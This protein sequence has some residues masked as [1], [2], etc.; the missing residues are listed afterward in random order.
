MHYPQILERPGD[1]ARVSAPT[2]AR[3]IR[4]RNRALVLRTLM[5]HAAASRA[6]LSR[7]TGLARPTISE[8]VRD[9]LDDGVIRE[10]GMSQDARPG[11]PAVMLEFDQRAVQVIALD[12]STP[13]RI[14]GALATP[15]G[16]IDHRADVALD[17]A[18][19]AT[20]IA[21]LAVDLAGRA[22]SAPLGIG[23][24]APSG[25][26]ALLGLGPRLADDLALPV[27]VFDDADLV[28]DAELRF[29]AVGTD[30]LL[31]RLGGRIGTAIRVVG[32]DGAPVE[33]SI[34]ARELAHVVAG[35]DP[36]DRC[37]CGR[38][39][40]VHAWAST[41]ALRRRLDEP[42]A[43]RDAVLAEAGA[44]LG[45]SLS[46]IAAAVD[47]PSI[48]LSGPSDIATPAFVEA[49]ATAVRAASHP[50]LGPA[51][52]SSTLDDAVLRGAAARVVAAAFSPR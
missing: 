39:G 33:R 25:S 19:P 37:L 5:E 35:G 42:G 15:D 49:T 3:A 40:C 2:H 23:I 11:K 7:L 1:R 4:E 41:P 44:R 9:L 24:G 45:T 14:T 30:F 48:L 34:G 29:G 26:P 16:R 46:V 22:S 43:D 36:G 21:A 18:D 8:V 52:A 17:D 13:G 38:D 20:A 12:L 31:V 50:S 51:V 6:D 28:A 47:L 10:S 32:D 27:H